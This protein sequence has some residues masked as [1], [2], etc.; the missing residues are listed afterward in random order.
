MTRRLAVVVG[1]LLAGAAGA[2]DSAPVVPIQPMRPM[3]PGYQTHDGFYLQLGLGVGGA[4]SKASQFGSSAE[5]SGTGA[6]LNLAAGGA[7]NPELLLGGRIW[8][9]VV[10]NPNVKFDGVDQGSAQGD[11]GLVGYGFDL[12]YY[13][14]PSNFYLGA[15]PA[16][17]RIHV[18]DSLSDEY[19][20]WGFGF[21]LAAGKEWW[22]S[23][24]W[25]LGLDLEFVRSSN[26]FAGSGAPTWDTNWFGV[27]FSATFN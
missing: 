7:V 5:I 16:F 13:F 26:K 21:R 2:Q 6:V 9:A 15:S 23:D 22:V 11:F 8:S 19:S 14:N 17:T 27:A 24:N 25:G 4:N 12:V 3:A 20:D 1:L 10:S 18:K